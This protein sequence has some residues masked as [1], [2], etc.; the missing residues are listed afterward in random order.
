M[1]SNTITIVPPRLFNFTDL[2]FNGTATIELKRKIDVCQWARAMLLVRVTSLPVV[3]GAPMD[4]GQIVVKA[5]Y[6]SFT[7]EDPGA[8]PYLAGGGYDIPGGSVTINNTVIAPALLSVY[9][10]G[11]LGR[12]LRVQLVGSR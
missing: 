2:V 4:G 9:L 1:A 12:M 11:G 10:G 8:M 5:L 7:E 3:S 6:D